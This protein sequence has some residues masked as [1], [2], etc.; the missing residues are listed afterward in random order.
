MITLASGKALTYVLLNR[1]A[2]ELCRYWNE[3]GSFAEYYRE[4]NLGKWLGFL[5]CLIL[6]SFTI[7]G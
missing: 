4:G 6:A 2:A 7:A 3:P 1:I 5:A